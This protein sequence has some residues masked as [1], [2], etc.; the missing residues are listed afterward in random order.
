MGKNKKKKIKPDQL[1]RI[2]DEFR[3]DLNKF[4]KSKNVGIRYAFKKFDK[5][6]DGYISFSEFENALRDNRLLPFFEQYESI[7]GIIES[8]NIIINLIYL[9]IT[10]NYFII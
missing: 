7:D 2:L 5:D 10:L 1:N 3:S 6:N 9:T 8:N 4:L